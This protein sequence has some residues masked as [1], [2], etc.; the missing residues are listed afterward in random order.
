MNRQE[1]FHGE[2]HLNSVSHADRGYRGASI[3]I[4]PFFMSLPGST[5]A[6][7]TFYL[8]E[9]YDPIKNN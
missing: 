8:T 3:S 7:D 9:T 6:S 2:P 5:G 4:F 1:L